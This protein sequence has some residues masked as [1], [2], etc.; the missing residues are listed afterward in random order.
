VKVNFLRTKNVTVADP[1]GRSYRS[2]VQFFSRL[3]IILNAYGSANKQKQLRVSFS[4]V[5]HAV[6]IFA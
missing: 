1:P 3:N 6:Y 4:H 5:S 2:P